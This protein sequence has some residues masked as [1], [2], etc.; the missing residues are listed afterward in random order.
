MG[1]IVHHLNCGS[2]CP[3]GVSLSGA[4]SKPVI[5]HCLL[6]ETRDGLV[7]VDTG[8][9]RA[10]AEDPISKLGRL[11]SFTLGIERE[12]TEIFAAKD[13][14]EQLGYSAA[15]V[16][17]II[18]THLDFDHCG[19]LV[20]F[21]EASVHV[22]R[23]E[24]ERALSP[25]NMMERGRYLAH[26]IEHGPKWTEYDGHDGEKWF[27]FDTVRELPGVHSDILLVP[28][29]GHTAGHTGIAVRTTKGWVLHAGDAYYQRAELFGEIGA[30]GTM[31][32]NTIHAS[33]QSAR[34][35]QSRLRELI[36]HHADIDVFCRHDPQEC[37]CT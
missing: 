29:F 21:P 6:V 24:K 9:G 32:G 20:D 31:V 11:R 13:L 37:D 5:N 28:L 17:H 22:F 27:G 10:I 12:N 25:R 2:S 4:F 34:A 30:W 16:R 23:Q 14:I 33:P 35:N 19:D 18:P 26:T 15:D 7:L 1:L 36:E 3:R 8:M